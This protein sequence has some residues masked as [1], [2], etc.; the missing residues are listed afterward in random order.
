M[1]S[2]I[3]IVWDFDNTMIDENCDTYIVKELGDESALAEMRRLYRAGVEWLAIMN[4]MFA[5][6]SLDEQ[7]SRRVFASIPFSENVAKAL[8]KSLA[9]ECIDNIVV[10]DANSLFVDYI[11]RAKGI[12]VSRF[13]A[14]Y[15]NRAKLLHTDDGGDGN[16]RIQV[17][18]FFDGVEARHSCRQLLQPCAKRLCKG[19]VV[20]AHCRYGATSTVDG[21]NVP[22]ACTH[23]VDDADDPFDL[24]EASSSSTTTTKDNDDDVSPFESKYDKIVVIG[25][26]RGDFCMSLV[27]TERDAILARQDYPLAR[28]L[29]GHAEHVRAPVFQWRVENFDVV[30]DQALASAASL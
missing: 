23:V 22:H 10:S 6:L 4:E 20:R 7:K 17:C 1:S 27:A 21:F 24:I 14:V 8:E 25:D 30:L 18:G 16:G 2:K 5:R 12:D 28:L 29:K 19:T 26:G 11:M 15:T 3:L 9:N 13:E